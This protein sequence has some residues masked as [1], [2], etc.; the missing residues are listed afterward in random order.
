MDPE[1]CNRFLNVS[2]MSDH[3]TSLLFTV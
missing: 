2:L 3:K 1:L